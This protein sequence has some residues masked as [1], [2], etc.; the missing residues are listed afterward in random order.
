MTILIQRSDRARHLV[1][2]VSAGEAI[3]DFLMKTLRDEGVGCG[4]IRGGGVLAEV[5]LRAYDPVVAALGAVRHI[6]GPMQALLL[7][8]SIARSNAK[9]S[10]SLR[11]LLARES[12]FGLQTLS[13]QL[14]SARVV[15]LELFVT[16]LE[17]LSLQRA[18]ADGSTSWQ[19]ALEASEQV[20]ASPRPRPADAPRL[21]AAI[22]ARPPRRVADLDAPF[23]AVGD[24]VDH[25]AF[26]RCDVVKSDGD[27]LHVKVHKDGRVREIAL[28]MLRVSPQG[29]EEDGRRR[30]KLERRM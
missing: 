23:P 4:W 27:R 22:P 18:P 17:E 15:T 6:E 30:F 3:P 21:R 7:E 25:F 14:E 13:G 5:S 26:G 28:G 24:T 2:Q 9:L 8:G 11:A 20:E 10:V 29:D 1:L 19:G 12:D 16:A